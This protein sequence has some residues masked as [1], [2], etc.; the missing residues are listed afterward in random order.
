MILLIYNKY[1]HISFNDG[2]YN[3]PKNRDLMR[4]TTIDLCTREIELRSD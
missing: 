4:K 2:I 3:R 1:F